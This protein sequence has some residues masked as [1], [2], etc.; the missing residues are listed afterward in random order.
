VADLTG[1]VAWFGAEWWPGF[2]GIRSY[3]GG[4]RR[5]TRN[6]IEDFDC[7]QEV[8]LRTKSKHYLGSKIESE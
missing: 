2:T 5:L 1:Q 4:W 3:F 8:T 6:F 7:V